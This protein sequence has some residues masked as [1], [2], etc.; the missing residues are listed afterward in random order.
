MLLKTLLNRHYISL[1]LL[2]LNFSINNILANDQLICIELNQ[3]LNKNKTECINYNKPYDKG[4]I[5]LSETIN[6][7]NTA[8]LLISSALV[9]LMTPGLSFFYAGL[10]GEQMVSNTIMM[11]FI[12]MAIVSIQFFLW[13]YSVSFNS[14]NLF[15]WY[16]YNDVTTNLSGIYGYQVPAIAFALFQTQF[17][18]ITPALLSGGIIGRMKFGTFIIF[19]LL[20]TSFIYNPLAHWMWAYTLNNNYEIE[21]SG[22]EA[23]LGSLDFAGGTVIHISSGFGA[24]VAA[25]MVGKRYNHNEP[26]KPHN[27]PLVMIGGSLLW[28]GWFGFNGG[29]ALAADGIAALACMNTHLSACSGFLTWT[30]LEY[31]L[32]K[33]I[34]PS[35]SLSGAVCGLVTITPA[36][37]YVYP[38]VSVIFGIIGTIVGFFCVRL[39]NILRYDDTLDAFGIHGCAG[40]VGGIL[41]GFFA[42]N[43]V[44][45]NIKNG[46]FYGNPILLWHQFI[47]QILAAGYSAVGTFIILIILKYTLGLRV[48]EEKEK[49]GMDNSYHGGTAY[50]NN[51]NNNSN[52]S[53]YN[54]DINYNDNYNISRANPP[55]NNFSTLLT[56]PSNDSNNSNKS[57]YSDNSFKMI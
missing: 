35:G 22:W 53:L 57:N 37:G 49:A 55:D 36:C 12:S 26:I 44:N 7:G 45:P 30:L 25:I 16:G 28:F 33:K 29:S 17:A 23:K 10:S 42:S 54:L 2:L 4:S 24:L 43:D 41:T 34:D 6:S 9:M 18:S 50:S 39:K 46:L 47:A 13:G 56:P 32:D 11:S 38:W 31:I 27:I 1:I 14:F 15:S 3:Y 21:P 52:N 8:W 20:W 5:N 40:F 51:S 48:P 19:T